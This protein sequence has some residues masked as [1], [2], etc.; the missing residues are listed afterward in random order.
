MQRLVRGRTPVFS[1]S[2]GSD[3]ALCLQGFPRIPTFSQRCH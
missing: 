2:T 1:G 3:R